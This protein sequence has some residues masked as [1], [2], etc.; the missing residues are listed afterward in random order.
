MK[1]YGVYVK[2]L[3][4]DEVRSGG[5]GVNVSNGGGGGISAGLGGITG[6]LAGMNLG[7][8]NGGGKTVAGDR[9][10][11]RDLEMEDNVV[12]RTPAKN[13]VNLEHLKVSVMEL[14]APKVCSLP[15][16]SYML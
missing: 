7:M 16:S 2:F 4:G 1:R 12:A 15:L 9:Y 13:A 8:S 3:S 14:V 5:V 10:T 6:G 11:E